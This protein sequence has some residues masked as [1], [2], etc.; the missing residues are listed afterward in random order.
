M[1]DGLGLALKIDRPAALTLMT[2]PGPVVVSKNSEFPSFDSV[3]THKI[4]M[5]KR[6]PLASKIW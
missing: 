5:V 1:A 4:S 6:S 3:S 2:L